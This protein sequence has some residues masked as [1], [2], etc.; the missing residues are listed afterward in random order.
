MEHLTET[1]LNEYLDGLLN[2]SAQA[3]LEA[4]LS[5][6]AD[7][8]SRLASLQTVFETLAAL[9]ELTP[10]R[11]LTQ[12]IIGALPWGGFGLGWRLALAFQTGLSF[13][14]LMLLSPY[15]TGYIFGIMP[16][17]INRFALPELKFPHLLDFHFSPPV[18]VVAHLRIPALPITVT[19]A[20]FSIWIILGIAAFLLFAV[21]NFSLIFHHASKAR[22]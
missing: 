16:G 15:V 8:R 2:A 20:N 7:C 21:G 17:L 11:D 9:P 18:F 12:S 1:Q 22:K 5:D 13:G 6:C 4:H 19:Q 10:E 3:R 14:L